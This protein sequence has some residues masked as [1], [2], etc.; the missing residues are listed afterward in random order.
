MLLGLV[1]VTE[2]RRARILIQVLVGA[3]AAAIVAVIIDPSMQLP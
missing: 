3:L 2:H 1:D